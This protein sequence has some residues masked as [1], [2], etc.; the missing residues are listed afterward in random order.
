MDRFSGASSAD[1]GVPDPHGSMDTLALSS[2]QAPLLGT[3][4]DKR[5]FP[6]PTVEMDTFGSDLSR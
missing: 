1:A 2:R 6:E 4:F 5:E 3:P